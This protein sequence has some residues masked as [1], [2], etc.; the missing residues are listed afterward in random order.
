MCTQCHL[1]AGAHTVQDF[2]PVVEMPVLNVTEQR[3]D[4]EWWAAYAHTV[5][6]VCCAP[7]HASA[8]L[9]RD[10]GSGGARLEFEIV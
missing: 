4:E 6:G 1:C 3:A 5:A 10:I 2:R 8:A 9:N 7:E